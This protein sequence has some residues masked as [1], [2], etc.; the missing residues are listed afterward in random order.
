MK[1][2]KLAEN[3]PQTS[4][5]LK[6]LYRAKDMEIFQSRQWSEGDVYSPHDLSW[7]EMQKWRK[8][9]KVAV[10]VFDTLGINPLHEYKVGFFLG[11]SKIADTREKAEAN[12]PGCD[13]TIPLCGSI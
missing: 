2:I 8:S 13:R 9:K 1:R 10:D 12:F 3:N 11:W 5:K 4:D 7:E 6:S